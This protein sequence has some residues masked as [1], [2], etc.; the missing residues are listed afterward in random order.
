M[1]SEGSTESGL[2]TLLNQLSLEFIERCQERLNVGAEEYGPFKFLENDTL[3]MLLE[4]LLD[5]SNYALMTYVK[6][7]MLQKYLADQAPAEG[8]GTASFIKAHEKG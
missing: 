3:D 8:L 6:V 2:G 1:S 4:E 7:R 5:I